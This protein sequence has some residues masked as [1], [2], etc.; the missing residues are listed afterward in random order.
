VAA[1]RAQKRAGIARVAGPVLE[2]LDGLRAVLP[3]DAIVADDLCLP[4]YWSP[5]A[6]DVFEPRTLLHPGM[7]GTLGYALPAAIGAA[8]ARSDRV[9]VSLSGDGGFLYTSQELAT[10]VQQQVNLV[11]IVFNDNAYGAL[12]VVQDRVFGGRR[13]AVELRSP[14][15]AMLGTAYGA[16]GVKLS[17]ASEL[18][19][20]VSEAIAR[21]GVHVIECPLDGQFASIPP[22]WL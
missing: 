4:G 6:L 21:G 22:P 14:D 17:S 18:P 15:F 2:L 9:C 19:G 16:H 11:S 7:F 13:I 20:A 1:V 12:G 10:A 5:L 3:R 8:L